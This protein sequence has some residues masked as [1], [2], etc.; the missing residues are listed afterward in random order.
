V[1]PLLG[2][3]TPHANSLKVYPNPA[4]EE[5]TIESSEPLKSVVLIDML[6]KTTRYEL[7]VLQMKQTLNPGHIAQGIYILKVETASGG[8]LVQK[9][10]IER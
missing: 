5:I 4:K 6:G 10:Y 1:G 2:I 7:S 8:I 9:L 3:Y